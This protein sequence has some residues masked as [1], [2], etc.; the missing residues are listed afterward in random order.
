MFVKNDNDNNDTL[1]EGQTTSI[2][3]LPTDLSD[4]VITHEKRICS[5]WYALL[6]WQGVQLGHCR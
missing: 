4:G 2:R 6:D 5:N 1:K 3:N